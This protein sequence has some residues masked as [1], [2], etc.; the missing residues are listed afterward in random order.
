VSDERRDAASRALSALLAS[1]AA[2]RR[3]TSLAGMRRS[4]R[5]LTT[6]HAT[7][8]PSQSRLTVATERWVNPANSA[9][10]RKVGEDD[11][12]GMDLS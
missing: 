12:V 3:S 7:S 6:M 8:P 2:S 5:S 9:V 1:A 10:V 11:E 4:P